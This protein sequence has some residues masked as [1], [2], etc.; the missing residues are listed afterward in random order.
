MKHTNKQLEEL[1]D[2]LVTG[3]LTPA[4]ISRLMSELGRRGGATPTSKPKGF[5]AISPRRRREIQQA[6]VEARREQARRKREEK[7]AEID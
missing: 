2:D 4:F 3:Q 5:A 1:T 6:G 7:E